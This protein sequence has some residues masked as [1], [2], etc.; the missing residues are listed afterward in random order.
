MV[1]HLVNKTALGLSLGY[2]WKHVVQLKNFGV[3]ALK[4]VKIDC[5]LCFGGVALLNGSLNHLILFQLSLLLLQRK[6]WEHFGQ[7]QRR[8]RLL[9]FI[10]TST[11]FVW[12]CESSW[13]G[14]RGK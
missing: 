3:L 2:A 11:S 7:I 12:V 5:L 1:L 4:T 6:V 14:L 8:N 9:I 13:H 10:L